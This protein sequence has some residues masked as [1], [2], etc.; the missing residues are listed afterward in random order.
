MPGL[1][2]AGEGLAGICGARNLT[3]IAGHVCVTLFQSF[4]TSPGGISHGSKA[5]WSVQGRSDRTPGWL[6]HRSGIRTT[7]NGTPAVH[8]NDDA[9]GR[10]RVGAQKRCA[11]CR[12][13][14]DRPRVPSAPVGPSRPSFS[15]AALAASRASFGAWRSARFSRISTIVGQS[16]FR[17]SFQGRPRKPLTVSRGRSPQ[18]EQRS[19]SRQSS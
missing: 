17:Q 16:S 8:R 11:G 4:Q 19:S 6:R 14:L 13:G 12:Q 9:C 18:T 5:F 2:V 7:R 15:A 1:R 10:R 3:G